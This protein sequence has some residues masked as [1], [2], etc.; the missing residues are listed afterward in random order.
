MV[1]KAFSIGDRLPSGLHDFEGACDL[2]LFDAAG[3]KRGGNGTSFDHKILKTYALKTPFMLSGG[4]SIQHAAAIQ[5]LAEELETLTGVDLNSR[6]EHK[7]G[8]KDIQLVKDFMNMFG[9]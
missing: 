8:V 1:I 7:P 6:F 5:T 3:E 9:L 4:I 2:F